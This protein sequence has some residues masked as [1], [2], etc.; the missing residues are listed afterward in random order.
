MYL[1]SIGQYGGNI[2]VLLNELSIVF[3]DKGKY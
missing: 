1:W 3:I 2:M